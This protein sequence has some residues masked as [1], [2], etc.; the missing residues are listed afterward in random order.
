MEILNVAAITLWGFNLADIGS[1]ALI[2]IMLTMG[3]TLQLGD[4]RRELAAPKAIVAGLTAQLVLLPA[5]AFFLA[6]LF[7]PNPS[8]IM[9]LIVLS[10]CP[11]GATSNF[12]T[13][14]AGGNVATSI[15]LTT[16]SGLIVIFSIPLLVNFAIDLYIDSD[17][18]VYLPVV[19]SM[20]RIFTLIVL[21]V[22]CGMLLKKYFPRVTTRVEPLLT[23]LSFAVILFTMGVILYHVFPVFLQL[24]VE[25][26]LI[27][28]AL[29]VSMM[30][31]GFVLATMVG[32][33]EGNK[34]CICIEVG[35]QNYMLSIIITIGIL[36]VPQFAIVP[37]LYL[38]VMY[39][40]VFSF[41]AYC[42]WVRDN[43]YA[44]QASLP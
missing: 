22:M 40:T 19:P 2:V 42:R 36:Q 28:L 29:N 26:G 6:W 12:F 4:F 20:I 7:E 37:I 11:S 31:L 39:V 30:L 18:R 35:V 15:S 33:S 23:R 10:C 38:F 24:M 17:R 32:L 1:I 21:P 5:M 13:Y 3:F 34:R 43:R 41:I 14:L 27:T 16:L 44:T 25:A 9:G 8:L